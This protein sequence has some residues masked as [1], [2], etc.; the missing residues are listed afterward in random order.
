MYPHHATNDVDTYITI[1]IVAGSDRRTKY[2]CEGSVLDIQCEEGTVINLV[3]ANY[4][5]FSIAICNQQGL[6]HWTVNCAARNTI[7]IVE[8]MYKI[9][10]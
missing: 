9:I 7:S 6:T 8:K 1:S 5:R 4:G 10:F 3:R 2:G